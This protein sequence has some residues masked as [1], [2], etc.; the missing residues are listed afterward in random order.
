LSTADAQVPVMLSFALQSGFRPT[1]VPLFNLSYA[2]VLVIV[3]HVRFAGSRDGRLFNAF[4]QLFLN[5]SA[6]VAIGQL[7]WGFPK[8]LKQIDV[9]LPCDGCGDQGGVFHVGEEGGEMLLRVEY[10]LHG[11]VEPIDDHEVF[12]HPPR[13]AEEPAICQSPLGGMWSC[14]CAE[15]HSATQVAA[16]GR[17]LVGESLRAVLP[18]VPLGEIAFEGAVEVTAPWYLSAPRFGRGGCERE[19]DRLSAARASMS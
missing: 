7:L 3:P 12:R 10:A 1:K 16:R 17:L 2:E 14:F 15:L 6:A 11:P 5:S 9:S 13:V 8:A 4:P 19:Y 18:A